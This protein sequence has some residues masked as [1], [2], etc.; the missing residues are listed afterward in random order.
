MIK[1]NS[2]S[3]VDNLGDFILLLQNLNQNIQ[4]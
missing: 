4:N 3:Y 2:M 1:F